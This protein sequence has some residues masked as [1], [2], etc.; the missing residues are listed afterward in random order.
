MTIKRVT[1]TFLVKGGRA[2]GGAA[3]QPTSARRAQAPHPLED[4][5]EVGDLR[6]ALRIAIFHR[7]ATMPTFPNRYAAC[8]GSMEA[9]ETPWETAQREL[10]E[11]TNFSKDYQVL[12]IATLHSVEAGL[13]VDV[14]FVSPRSGKSSII[15]V[16]PFVIHV[17][18]DFELALK[19]TEHDDFRWMSL[20]EVEDLDQQSKTVPS[21]ALAFHHATAGQYDNNVTKEERQW[22]SDKANGKSVI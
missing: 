3:K 9:G 7:C 16:Y 22:A 21:L 13:Y 10:Q 1:T 20:E 5:A 17:V 6:G 18:D 19:G 2:G 4:A 11:E 12:P 8:S 15:R 14:D